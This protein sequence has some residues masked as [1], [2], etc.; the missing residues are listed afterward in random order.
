MQSVLISFG[1]CG[2]SASHFQ[3]AAFT[4]E[5]A[6]LSDNDTPTL[7]ATGAIRDKAAVLALNGW[8]ISL[9]AGIVAGDT[10]GSVGSFEPQAAALP[11][12]PRLRFRHRVHFGFLA[13]FLSLALLL[14]F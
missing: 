6:A 12:R 2:V 8:L 3:R 10:L 14:F 1:S 13:F 11:S 7:T 4:K 5:S 9:E